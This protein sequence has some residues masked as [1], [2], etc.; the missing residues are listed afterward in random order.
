MVS[1]AAWLV[2]AY[3]SRMLLLSC[4]SGVCSHS[5]LSFRAKQR[6]GDLEI[7]RTTSLYDYTCLAISCCLPPAL[8]MLQQALSLM[9]VGWQAGF[10]FRVC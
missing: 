4:L 7:Y 10:S 6:Q 2:V 3:R 5:G 9:Q 8:S 1:S